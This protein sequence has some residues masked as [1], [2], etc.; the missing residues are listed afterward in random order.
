VTAASANLV[1]AAGY[2]GSDAIITSWSGSAWQL[3]TLPHPSTYTLRAIDTNGS[4]VW[5]AGF[6]NDG[7]VALQLKN[8]TWHYMVIPAAPAGT[9]LLDLS[10]ASGSDIWAGLRQSRLASMW[11]SAAVLDP[12]LPAA[13]RWLAVGRMSGHPESAVI[14][15]DVYEQTAGPAHSTR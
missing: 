13:A 8:G 9:T 2:S 11:L 14:S 15:H 12:A 4:A 10:V 7:A 6:G 5:A 1:W 3:D